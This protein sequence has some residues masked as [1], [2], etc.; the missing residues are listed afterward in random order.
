MKKKRP[1]SRTP[2]R[3]TRRSSSSSRRR[4]RSGSSPPALA[5]VR[6][7]AS[8]SPSS[9]R[10]RSPPP[11][12]SRMATSPG[13]RSAAPTTRPRRGERA[14][15][16]RGRRAPSRP[17]SI[18]SVKYQ[19]FDEYSRSCEEWLSKNYKNEYH[20]DRRVPRRDL[21]GDGE[22]VSRRGLRAG[23]LL[24]QRRIQRGRELPPLQQLRGGSQALQGGPRQEREVPPSACAA[25]PVRS[26]RVE[27]DRERQSDG[28][29]PARHSGLRLPE[30]GGPGR[31]RSPSDAAQQQRLRQR[32][33]ERLRTREEEPS[34]RARRRR[35]FH[36]G[37]QP[38]RALLPRAREAERRA[39]GR[40]ERAR[41][42]EKQKVDTQAIDLAL[43][44]A[45]QGIR[46]N[47][48]Y[49]SIH[50]T[51]G[52]IFVQSGD[53]NNAVRRFGRRGSSTRASSRRT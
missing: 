5:S 50:N 30:R 2:R 44:V 49:A 27:R 32:R 10:R 24:R 8:S 19:Y 22:E 33:G 28:R 39:E 40:Q 26:R 34:A 52:L 15:E 17:A 7:G 16:A 12:P 42:S 29:V 47:P 18:Y 35:R 41:G 1:P 38:A 6:C 46:K 23:R 4:R 14:A 20:Q 53:L 9:A 48:N 13:K 45:S 25:R 11:G 31:A 43:L 37:V 51:A 3:S 21:L 36:A